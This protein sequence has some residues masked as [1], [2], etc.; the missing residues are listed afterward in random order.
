MSQIEIQTFKLVQKLQVSSTCLRNQQ[1]RSQKETNK[2]TT[3]QLLSL[4]SMILT[5]P[6]TCNT[7]VKRK[8]NNVF[9]LIIKST[10]KN[11]KTLMGAMDNTNI[12][13]LEIDERH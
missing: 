1:N 9:Y 11:T 3:N 4:T 6:T 2:T 12:L 8:C 7:K 10:N 13:Q 5:S